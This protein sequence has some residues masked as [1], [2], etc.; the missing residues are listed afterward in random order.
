MIASAFYPFIGFR[1]GTGPGERELTYTTRALG[2]TPV[3][4]VLDEAAASG[5]GYLELPARHAMR[6]DAKAIGAVAAVAR[7]FVERGPVLGLALHQSR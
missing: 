4:A 3:D 1:T 2:R 7:Q 5:W 6:T